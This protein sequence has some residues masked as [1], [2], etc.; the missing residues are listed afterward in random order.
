MT[1]RPSNRGEKYQKSLPTIPASSE[2]TFY[3]LVKPLIDPN[4]CFPI[5]TTLFLFAMYVVCFTGMYTPNSEI[6]SMGLFFVVHLMF[7][8]FIIKTLLF[9]KSPSDASSSVNSDLVKPGMMYIL[10]TV[11]GNDVSNRLSFIFGTIVG[12]GQVRMITSIMCSTILVLL[13]MTITMV[14]YVKLHTDSVANNAPIDFGIHNHTKNQLKAILIAETIMLWVLYM[15]YSGYDLLIYILSTYFVRGRGP[16][17]TRLM[18]EWM[19]N[20]TNVVVSI[21]L[22]ALS[23]YSTTSVFQMANDVGAI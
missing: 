9:S 20:M 3:K 14:I 23:I 6:I 7:T 8:M 1:T 21:T 19:V 18:S 10:P 17:G 4:E 12:F 22:L 13:T 5:L 16:V 15:I 2:S 11:V